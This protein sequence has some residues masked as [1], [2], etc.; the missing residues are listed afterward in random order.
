[1]TLVLVLGAA[2]AAYAAMSKGSPKG[3]TVTMTVAQ[4]PAATTPATTTPASTP[5]PGTTATT[6]KL[7][8]PLGTSKPPK[9]PL[10]APTPKA[11]TTTPATSTTG[12]ETTPTKTTTTTTTGSSGETKAEE[13]QPILLDTNAA[14]TYN[15]YELTAADFGDPSLTIDGDSTTAWTAQVEAATAPKMAEGVLIDLKS[16]VQVSALKLISATPGMTVQVYGAN[17]ET[18]PSSITDPGWTALSHQQTIK[19]KHTKIKFRHPKQAYRFIVLW[20]SSAGEAS[21]PQAPGHVD[22]NELELLPTSGA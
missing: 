11:T 2:A 9:I 14:S 21:T 19:K 15:P 10:T 20:I 16:K 8:L 22:V 5:T 3:H 1:M 17:G 18:P 12:T 4:A 13:P 6:G 7:K